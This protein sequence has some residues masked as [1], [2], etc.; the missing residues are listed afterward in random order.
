[1]TVSIIVD[2]SCTRLPS[3]STGAKYVE[4]QLQADQGLR[5]PRHDGSDEGVDH[6]QG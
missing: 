6:H 3:T 4:D 5:P 2:Q 1:M